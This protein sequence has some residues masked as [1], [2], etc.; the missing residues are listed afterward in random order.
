MK[1]LVQE[2]ERYVAI[3][4]EFQN[5]DQGGLNW[6]RKVSRI[7]TPGT[8]IDEKFMNPYENNFLLAVSMPL[9]P[10]LISSLGTE[11]GLAWLDLSTGDFFTQQSTVGMLSGDIARIGPRE[12]VVPEKDPMESGNEGQRDLLQELE[13]EGNLITYYSEPKFPGS[14]VVPLNSVEDWNQMLEAPVP[15]DVQASMSVPEVEAGNILLGY[16]QARLPGMHMKLQPPIRKTVEDTMLI[17]SR[18]MKGLEIK[19]TLRDNLQVGSLL[20]TVKRT[21]TKSGTRLLSNWLSTHPFLNNRHFNHFHF[22]LLTTI[23]ASPVTSISIIDN[24]LNLVEI[25]RYNFPLREKVTHLLKKSHD[26]Q[27]IVQKFTLGRG[28]AD[29]MIALATTIHITNDLKELLTSKIDSNKSDAN[30]LL[31]ASME[32]LLKRLD[33][34]LTLAKK[35][36]KSID[37]E[38]LMQQQRNEQSEAAEMI[39]R[40]QEVIKDIK[41]EES[42][43]STLEDPSSAETKEILSSAAAGLRKRRMLSGKDQE[44]QE[45]WIMKTRFAIESQSLIVIVTAREIIC[46]REICCFSFL[47]HHVFLSYQIGLFNPVL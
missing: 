24:R 43:E 42:S 28:D 11:V 37:E 20:H 36:N 40:V 15:R 5:P 44:R 32:A 25:F 4:E 45:A 17:D 31:W 29:D 47:F 23:T 1:A 12:I 21:I 3:S 38:G 2:H 30:R 41:D 7:I 14:D 35:I 19:T 9:L 26:S 13:R 18:S 46:A 27:R 8:L 22:Q 10:D 16:A 39:A 33:I 34:P 6:D